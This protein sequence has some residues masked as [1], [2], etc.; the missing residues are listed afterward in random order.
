MGIEIE[1]GRL[2]NRNKNPMG[3]KA[4]QE[5]EY[6]LKRCKPDGGPVIPSELTT[7][8]ATLNKRV[9]NRG[10]TAREIL[11]QQDSLTGD[12]LNFNDKLLAK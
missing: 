5:L 8:T 9:H 12:Q 2:K 11:L 10:L 4:V 3:E 6:E 1:V 7:I